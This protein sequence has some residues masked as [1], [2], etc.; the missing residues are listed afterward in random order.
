SQKSYAD[1][2]KGSGGK[3]YGFNAD[4]PLVVDT[5]NDKIQL[6]AGLHTG[7]QVTFHILDAS[8]GEGLLNNQTYYVR[9]VSGGYY[10]FYRSADDA[11]NNANKINLI[12]SPH[13]AQEF[14]SAAPT[15]KPDS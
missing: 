8:A 6:G 1:N 7:D 15:P 13:G 14:V 9:D 2:A 3:T 12:G 4:T 10:S 11:K 5:T